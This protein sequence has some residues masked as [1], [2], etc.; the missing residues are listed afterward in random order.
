MSA[1]VRFDAQGVLL[2]YPDPSV[3]RP[4]HSEASKVSDRDRL[5]FV[6]ADRAL[7]LLAT[8]VECLNLN[9]V[10]PIDRALDVIGAALDVERARLGMAVTAT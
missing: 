1:L 7:N 5:L 10:A 4:F 9:D 8:I 3:K 6:R 2:M